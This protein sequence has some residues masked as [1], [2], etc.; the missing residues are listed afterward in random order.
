MI[1]VLLIIG[2]MIV[3]EW[4]LGPASSYTLG[5]FFYVALIFGIV[6]LAASSFVLIRRRK[7]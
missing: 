3:V 7:E 2:A 6:L 5:N 1:S 4:I